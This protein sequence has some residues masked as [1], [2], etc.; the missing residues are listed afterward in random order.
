MRSVLFLDELPLSL[1]R[2]LW[3]LLKMFLKE[4]LRHGDWRAVFRLRAVGAS[5]IMPEQAVQGLLDLGCSVVRN[6]F[7][8]KRR[9]EV[10]WVY[11]DP[12]ALRWALM[13]KASRRI[14]KILAGPMIVSLPTEADSILMEEGV[15]AWLFF[16]SWYRDLFLREVS[17]AHPSYV[18][19]AGV[20]AEYWKPA[21]ARDRFE[22]LIYRKTM[23]TE[24]YPAVLGAL[25]RRSM[26][27]RL[28]QYGSYEVDEYREALRS[29]RAAIF[30]SRTE[31]QGLA[32]FEAWSTNVPTLHWDPG[33]MHYQGRVL[34][35]ASSCAYLSPACG[36][37][38]EGI[39]QME[40]ELDA[41]LAESAGL[42]PRETVLRHF[43]L[44]HSARRAADVIDALERGVELDDPFPDL[45]QP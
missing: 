3:T 40:D 23:E 16:S 17:E 9:H 28:I 33:E 36:R 1:V 4:G 35:G 21:P 13:A 20:D 25:E 44:A 22:V 38:F 2:R 41:L 10:A 42:T 26:P 27:I 29:A 7:E 24:I 8:T 15:D 30:I 11:K 31:T 18:S 5:M 45:V 32:M 37:R 43:T 34:P 14:G 12:R 39:E 6:D 19:F